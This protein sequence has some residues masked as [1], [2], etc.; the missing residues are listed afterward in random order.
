MQIDFFQKEVD[1]L[2]YRFNETFGVMDV[3]NLQMRYEVI[4]AIISMARLAGEIK[5]ATK[6]IFVKDEI[7][8]F[9]HQKESLDKIF[10]KID[11]HL[12][13]RRQHETGNS[14]HQRQAI[15]GSEHF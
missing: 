12:K 14:I 5:K 13:Q 8:L 7:K 1:K 3:C 6:K 11:E 10:N 15:A 9:I 4:L 2:Q